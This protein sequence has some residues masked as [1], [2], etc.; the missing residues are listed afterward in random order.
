MTMVGNPA[1]EDHLLRKRDGVPAVLRAAL[2]RQTAI[3]A[4]MFLLWAVLL[5][6]GISFIV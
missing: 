1:T 2:A 5:F 3:V 6:V 4:I